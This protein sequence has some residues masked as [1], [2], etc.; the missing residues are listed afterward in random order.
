MMSR[1]KLSTIQKLLTSKLLFFIVVVRL[2]EVQ[3]HQLVLCNPTE[4]VSFKLYLR[5][6]CTLISV[7]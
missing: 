1:K 5:Q 3:G 7:V 2:V 4:S 6:S